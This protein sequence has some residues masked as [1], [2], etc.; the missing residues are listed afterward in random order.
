MNVYEEVSLFYKN[1]KGEKCVFGKSV[2]GRNLYALFIGNH[3]APIGIS[4]AAIHGREWI[5]ALLSLHHAEK[6][7]KRGGVWILPLTNPDGALLSEIGITTV[8]P[9]KRHFLAE[10]NCGYN[11]SLWKA[12]AKGVDLNVNFDARWGTG[13]RNVF[14]PAPENYVGESPFCAPES[15]ALKE[16]TE[17]IR[18]DFTVS[19]HTKGEEIYWRFHQPF[20]RISRDKKLA[21]RLSNAI[22]CPLK[23]A[24]RSVGGYK[25]WCIE[26]LKIPAFTVEVGR[27]DLVHPLG[28]EVLHELKEKYGGALQALT[29]G[30]HGRK[31]HARGDQAR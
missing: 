3:E 22:N 1:F 15:R 24:K 11:F 18:P 13:A 4:Q 21:K 31:V 25:D 8:S 7:L 5:T 9:E 29:E 16:F 14:S 12:N 28:R 20:F 19:W 26:C 30:Y 17:Q 2:E 23:E 6:N 27:D 10:L